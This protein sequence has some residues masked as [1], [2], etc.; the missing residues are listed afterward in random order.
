MAFFIADYQERLYEESL[1]SLSSSLSLD[2]ENTAMSAEIADLKNNKLNEIKILKEKVEILE[3]IK[4]FQNESDVCCILTLYFVLDCIELKDWNN[5]KHILPILKYPDNNSSSFEKWFLNQFISNLY[6]HVEYLRVDWI[7]K[8]IFNDFLLK[9][10]KTEV[11]FE[12]IYKFLDK[13]YNIVS[14]D[15]YS[16]LINCEELKPKKMVTY[17]FPS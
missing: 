10:I 5:V 15:I 7:S 13:L 3:F 6:E 16:F 17:F 4:K 8:L 12:L 2:Y 9:N 1:N 14:H 11:S